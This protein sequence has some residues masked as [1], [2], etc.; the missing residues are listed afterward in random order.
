[1]NFT[2][3]DSKRRC[4]I[5]CA[6]EEGCKATA[7]GKMK[8]LVEANGNSKVSYIG[9]GLNGQA[10]VKNILDVIMKRVMYNISKNFHA[11]NEKMWWKKIVGRR[12]YVDS[13]MYSNAIRSTTIRFQL[14]G[15]ISYPFNGGC[16]TDN[17]FDCSFC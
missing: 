11:I 7:S 12:L 6:L 15:D 1:M 16:N 9:G 10:V 2:S 3:K 17:T 5:L 14:N 13:I 4:V 8:E